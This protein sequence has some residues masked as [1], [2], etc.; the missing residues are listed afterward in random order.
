M[1]Y[2]YQSP[3][4][5][6][7]IQFRLTKAQH[8]AIFKY[9]QYDIRRKTEY[10][11]NGS[12]LIAQH[13]TSL[14]WVALVLIPAFIIGTFM[15]GL[16]ATWRDLKRVLRQKHYGAFMEDR[17]FCPTDKYPPE[18]KPIIDIWLKEK[19]RRAND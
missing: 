11:Y 7:Y 3:A 4:E 2:K 17:A 6:G 14:W 16:P 18:F 5:R 10:F 9:R 19:A 13:F 15:N 1:D 8:N 12:Q